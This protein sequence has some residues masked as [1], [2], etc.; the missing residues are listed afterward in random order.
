MQS[1]TKQGN[2]E[3]PIFFCGN[4]KSGTVEVTG[5]NPTITYKKDRW[6]VR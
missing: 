3:I 6:G 2:P 5:Y 1:S 4:K